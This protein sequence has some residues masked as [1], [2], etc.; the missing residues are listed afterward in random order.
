MS[1][2]CRLECV[3]IGK[4]ATADHD[5]INAIFLYQLLAVLAV[6]NVA[7]DRKQRMRCYLVPKFFNF[8]NHLKVG[9]YLA[10]LFAGTQVD[11]EVDDILL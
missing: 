3:G 9:I 6:T 4:D 7:I 11:S 5:A 8:W 2:W 10:H 1:L